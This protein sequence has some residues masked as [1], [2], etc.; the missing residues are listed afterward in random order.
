MES[1][2]KK[3]SVKV[4]ILL[5][6]GIAAALLFLHVWFSKWTVVWGRIISD[7][8]IV[9]HAMWIVTNIAIFSLFIMFLPYGKKMN[10][11]ANGIYIGFFVALFTE[12]I[13]IPLSLF[14]FAAVS[15]HVSISFLPNFV[16]GVPGHLWL[17]YPT[18][19]Q[20]IG[21]SLIAFGMF[22]LMIGWLKIWN[23]E[24][25]VTNGIYKYTRH[26]QYC[27]ILLITGIWLFFF[28]SFITLAMWT[29][30]AL[31]YYRLAKSEE[32]SLIELYGNEYKNYCKKTGM[33][34][35]SIHFLRP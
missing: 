28:P 24:N 10:W 27:G 19:L 22:L 31:A 26:P 30:L 1:L 20:I 11:W 9:G 25:L 8:P 5:S 29:L 21:G 35:P 33:F 34:L 7:I 23:S 4:F 17:F 13:G 32:R 6:L 16:Y 15:N 3:T 14:F 18:H 2:G 12:M